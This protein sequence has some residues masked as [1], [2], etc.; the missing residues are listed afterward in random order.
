MSTLADYKSRCLSTRFWTYTNPGRISFTVSGVT[1]TP[2]AGAVYRDS[3]THDFTVVSA[4]ITA[5]NGTVVCTGTYDAAAA[6]DTLT[7]QS[8]TG[9]AT[10]SYS[11]SAQAGKIVVSLPACTVKVLLRSSDPTQTTF[12]CSTTALAPTMSAF[13]TW[14]QPVFRDAR[15]GGDYFMYEPTA[16]ATPKLVVNI[17]GAATVEAVIYM[18]RKIAPDD[19]TTALTEVYTYV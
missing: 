16:T 6:P 13:A 3:A 12:A 19:L 4:S 10:L 7:K 5:G 18:N 11:A 9:D 2:T 8:G 1:V 15:S 14:P 17:G